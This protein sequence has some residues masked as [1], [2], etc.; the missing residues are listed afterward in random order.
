MHAGLMA[1]LIEAPDKLLTT[2][3]GSPP[4]LVAN[5]C[6]AYATGAATAMG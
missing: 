6:A 4:T 2:G 5:T 1:T 3:L